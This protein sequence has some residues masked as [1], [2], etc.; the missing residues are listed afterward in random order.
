MLA[1]VAKGGTL[2]MIETTEDIR[3]GYLLGIK[4]RSNYEVDVKVK[5]IYFE[6]NL[7]PGVSGISIKPKEGHF[8]LKSENFSKKVNVLA[9]AD[10]DRKY[11]FFL[12]NKVGAGKVVFFNSTKNFEK[13]DR[14]LLFAGILDGLKAIPYPVAN[15]STI[16]LDDFPSP[17]YEAIKEPIKTEMNITITDFVY[18]VWWPDMKKIAK[19]FNIKYT[20]LLTFDYRNKINPPFSFSQ[21]DASRKT[22]NG[23][24]FIV[25]HWLVNDLEKN[26]FEK[27]FH[28]FNHVSLLKK[29]WPYPS[30]IQSS[31]KATKKKWL[32]NSYG[33]LPVSYV[34]PSNDIDK[35]GIQNLKTAMPSIKYMSSLYLGDLKEG[36]DREYDF[37]PYN[38]QLFDYPR[39]SSGYDMRDNVYVVN[40]LFHFT[41][42]W[43]HFV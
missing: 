9:W 5:G 19:D 29:G 37:E 38:N 30:A 15:T 23:R 33:D 34:P 2:F 18:S 32:V 24:E 36:G 13:E 41:G 6:K 40:S 7:L 42:L 43:H 11:P 10:S 27:G 14:G 35:Y 25:P 21:W 4:P 31:M 3:M 1:F 17:T 28:G 39:I 26:G 12:E 20:A 16:F 8:G 22:I